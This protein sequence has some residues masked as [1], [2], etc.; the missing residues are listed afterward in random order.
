TS[1]AAA[2]T[3]TSPPPA[4]RRRACA[5]RSL[6]GAA[7]RRPWDGAP[8]VADVIGG[9][10]GTGRALPE[11]MR[12][13]ACALLVLAGCGGT[14]PETAN[15]PPAG[16][17]RPTP[18]PTAGAAGGIVVDAS[19]KVTLVIPAGALDR[20]V[21][22]AITATAVAGAVPGTGYELSPS[23]ILFRAP[24]TLTIRYD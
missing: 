16:D 24:A 7:S 15:A 23:G 4:A 14:S 20:D 10:A 8:Q 17:A 18:A 9:D 21:G 6:T 13:I 11:G 2:T 19:G 3:S 1:T 22:I 5:P 12:K